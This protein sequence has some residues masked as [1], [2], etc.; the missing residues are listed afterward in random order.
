[1]LVVGFTVVLAG[2]EALRYCVKE[3]S[4]PPFAFMQWYSFERM[5]IYSRIQNNT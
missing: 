1:M 5:N 3:Y 4:A 2:W